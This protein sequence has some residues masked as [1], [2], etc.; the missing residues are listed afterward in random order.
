MK[1]SFLL[2]LS[3]LL[4]LG[5]L[6]FILK[7]KTQTNISIP[8]ASIEPNSTFELV[9]KDRK[10]VTGPETLSVKEGQEVTIK[11]TVDEDEELHVH[12]YDKSINLMKDVPG[13]LKFTANLTGRFPYELEDSKTELGN[14]EV[15]PK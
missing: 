15:S 5:G 8:S 7:P 13:E 2:A 14:L 10:L 11:I 6:F 3:V 1:N 9:V 12:G 4:L